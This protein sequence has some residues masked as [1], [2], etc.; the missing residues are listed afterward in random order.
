MGGYSKKISAIEMNYKIVLLEE[1]EN[2][3]D[4]AF[5]WYELQQPNLG[6]KFIQYIQKGINFIKIYP[7]ASER[8]IKNVH[9]HVI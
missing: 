9:R 8:K 5:L 7:E 6:K 4:D 1:A 2:D 3:L